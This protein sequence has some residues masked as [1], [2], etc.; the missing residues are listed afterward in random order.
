MVN[1]RAQKIKN[2]ARD[3]PELEVDGD[4]EGELLVVG[5]GGTYGSITEAVIKAR[6]KGYKVSQTHFKYLN[7][8]PQNTFEVLSK[9]K[10]VLVPE[11]NLGQLAKVIKS[12]FLIPVRQLN[13]VRGLPLRT[14]EIESKIIELLGG[15][16]N[17]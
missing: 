15:Q 11:I 17:G 8:F 12:E 7:P 9:F 5:W 1:L 13:V 10:K 3:I 6:E 2:M 4:S 14:S 16:N